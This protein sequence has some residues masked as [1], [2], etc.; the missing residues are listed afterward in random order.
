LAL[1]LRTKY[2]A[3]TSG[4]EAQGLS[5]NFLALALNSKP[6]SWLSFFLFI[7]PDCKLY[8]YYYLFK[9]CG[10]LIPW[11]N[12]PTLRSHHIAIPAVGLTVLLATQCHHCHRLR[13]QINAAATLIMLMMMTT[14]WY[15][16]AH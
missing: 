7:Y 16:T 3:F 9:V 13:H 8:Y 1:A 6:T 14:W 15:W 10:V 2:S 11:L 12:Y 5:I 4:L